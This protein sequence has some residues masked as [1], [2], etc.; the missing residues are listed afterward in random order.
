[1]ASI[2]IIILGSFSTFLL[3]LESDNYKDIIL[4]LFPLI[5]FLF[6]N[7]GILNKYK[8]FLGDSGSNLLG[9]LIAFIA[10]FI[11]V[12][13]NVHPAIIVWP[14]AYIVYEFL[15]VTILRIINNSGTFKPGK[16]HLHYEI[17]K[18]FGFN[19]I[20]TVTLIFIA[21]VFVI[22]LGC[23]IFAKLGPVV[24]IAMFILFFIFYFA[25]KFYIQKMIKNKINLNCIF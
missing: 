25:L 18:L 17:M 1:M 3:F 14:L 7:L 4:I 2:S 21:N 20:K 16:D 22:I 15:S 6:F 12:E 11:Y 5:I 19:Q 10:I 24:S 8:I 9:F 23:Y 13:K